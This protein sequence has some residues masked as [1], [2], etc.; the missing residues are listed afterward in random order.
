LPKAAKY[1]N[2]ILKKGIKAQKKIL[3]VKYIFSGLRFL[4]AYEN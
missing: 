1:F 3:L 2:Q 4:I